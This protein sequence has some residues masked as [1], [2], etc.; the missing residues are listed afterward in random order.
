MANTNGPNGFK[1]ARHGGGGQANRLTRYHIAGS[2]G[3]NIVVGD[4][5]VPTGTT[6]NVARPAAATDRLVGVFDGCFYLD[7]NQADPQYN[8]IWPANQTV[9]SGSVPDCQVYDD[10]RTLFEAQMSGAFTLASIGSLADL[11]IGSANTT[12]K[13]SGDAIDS[14]TVDASGSVFKIDDIV[15]RPDNAVGNY[16]KVLV[17]ISKHYNGGAMTGI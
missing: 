15:D 17:Y 11:V 16:A 4:A 1:L 14:T 6:K 3:S 2:Y 10:P 8:R 12:I 13:I 7:P 5:V 9:V